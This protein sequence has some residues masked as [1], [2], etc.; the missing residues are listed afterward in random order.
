MLDAIL[1]I[2]HAELPAIG[3][4][5]DGIYRGKYFDGKIRNCITGTRFTGGYG[6][7]SKYYSDDT[8]LIFNEMLANYSAIMKTSNPQIGSQKLNQYMNP[9]LVS[10]IE[11]SY[12]QMALQQ[13]IIMTNQHEETIKL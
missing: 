13:A 11:N 4:Y 3:D 1:R 7:G 6:H 10:M 12:I 2:E 9:Q 8:D 5:F